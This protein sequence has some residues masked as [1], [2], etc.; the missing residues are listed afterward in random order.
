MNWEYLAE[1]K[2]YGGE[3]EL[4]EYLVAKKDLGWELIGL[5][6]F[7]VDEGLKGLNATFRR[8]RAK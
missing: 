7:D 1:K 2:A 3:G 5:V 8:V 6:C 4:M